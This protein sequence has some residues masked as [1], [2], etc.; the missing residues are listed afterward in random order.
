MGYAVA[1]GK[2]FTIYIHK[3]E[4]A[5]K[6]N[7]HAANCQLDSRATQKSLVHEKDGI[8]VRANFKKTCP[9]QSNTLCN[10][11]NGIIFHMLILLLL[12]VSVI[13]LFFPYAP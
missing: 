11:A 2:Y 9:P 6:N 7:P 13:N 4:A 12:N 3:R 10:I 5:P 8:F 1:N